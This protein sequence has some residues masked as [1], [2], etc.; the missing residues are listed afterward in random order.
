MSI[1]SETTHLQFWAK[2]DRAIPLLYRVMQEFGVDA[3]APTNAQ[4]ERY[5]LEFL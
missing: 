3:Y 4:G 5:L 2:S 1:A